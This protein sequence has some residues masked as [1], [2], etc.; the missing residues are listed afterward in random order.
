M[1]LYE[2]HEFFFNIISGCARFGKKNVSLILVLF[3][4]LFL[5][6]GP[7][8]F[9]DKKKVHSQNIKRLKPLT[10]K[11]SSHETQAT[12]FTMGVDK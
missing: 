1:G 9:S 3:I 10:K 12:V 8:Q 4:V 2:F 7:R 5:K 11:F 6:K